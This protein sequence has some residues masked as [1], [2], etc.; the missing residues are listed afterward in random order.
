MKAKYDYDKIFHSY[1]KY[2]VSTFNNTMAYDN[3]IFKFKDRVNG[4]NKLLKGM[5]I[6]IKYGKKLKTFVSKHF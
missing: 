4:Y 2:R 6:G 3:L 1:T 5:E